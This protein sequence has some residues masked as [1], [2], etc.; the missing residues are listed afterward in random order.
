MRDYAVELLVKMLE[1]YSPSGKEEEL[2]HFLLKRL[3]DFKIKSKIDKVGNVIAKIGQ[4]KPRILLCG[5][6]D[7]VP[8]KME[9]RNES[10][11]LYGR[12]AVDAKSSLASMIITMKELNKLKLPGEIT[13]AGVVEE[14]ASS[15]GIKNLIKDG[16]STDYAIFGEPSGVDNITIGYKGSLNLK[17]SCET[18]G[19]HSSAPWLFDNVIEKA[20]E[21][22]G[23]IKNF[24]FPN[25]DL[26]S[27]F[28]SLSSCL[29]Y[30]YGG[31][32]RNIT[33]SKCEF[34][35]DIRIPPQLNAEKVFD[36]IKDI[37]DSFGRANPNIDIRISSVGKTKPFETSRDSILVRSFSWAIR[38]TRKN[39]VTLLKKTG[40]ADINELALF[41][42]IPMIAYGPGD[43]H[44]DHTSN[45]HII[46]DDYLDSI[47]IY[48]E[49]IMR[50]FDLYKK[51]RGKE[52]GHKS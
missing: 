5:H 35:V 10:G 34:L 21:L 25:E 14:E 37:I 4:G 15:L 11:I 9:V 33:P 49:A 26:E 41:L 52:D 46:I 3:E 19:G 43:S 12:G 48:R 7:T 50:L 30:M 22:W 47:H 1:T 23:L 51:E 40:T 28:Y 44:L 36:S 8:G 45:E 32:P 42:K 24:H 18:E 2:S 16:I 39:R 6:L 13:F 31:E 27:R 17:I 38:K 29:V 20:Y